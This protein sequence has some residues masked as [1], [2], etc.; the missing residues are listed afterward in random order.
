MESQ[1]Y[2]ISTLI[3]PHTLDP[4]TLLCI[5]D[6]FIPT[7]GHK[8]FANKC[9]NVNKLEGKNAQVLQKMDIQ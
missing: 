5:V 6:W 7:L 3:K 8:T 1:N 2:K 4:R 9:N